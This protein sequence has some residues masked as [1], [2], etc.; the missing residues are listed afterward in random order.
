MMLEK[1]G[2]EAGDEAG[3]EAG[4]EAG[5]EAGDAGETGDGSWEEIIVTN[6][7]SALGLGSRNVFCVTE[8]IGSR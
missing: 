2:G 8:F 5:D 6:R 4:G 7:I 3:D 1:I